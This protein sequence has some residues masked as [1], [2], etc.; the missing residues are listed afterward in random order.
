MSDFTY[1]IIYRS[2]EDESTLEI[3]RMLSCFDSEIEDFHRA[4]SKTFYDRPA[5]VAHAKFLAEKH[6]KV[7]E[8][9]D[10]ESS[11]LD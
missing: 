1:F 11:L 5:A 4:S 8:D 9:T 6:G 10:E 2:K 3:L 7:F